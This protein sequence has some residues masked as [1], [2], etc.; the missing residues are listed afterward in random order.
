VIHEKPSHNFEKV[1]KTNVSRKLK[2][3]I[4]KNN[5]LVLLDMK[6]ILP[7]DKNK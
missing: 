6:I 5:L 3:K 1:L 2:E 4:T 7:F